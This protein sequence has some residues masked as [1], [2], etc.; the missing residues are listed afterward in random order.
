MSLIYDSFFTQKHFIVGLQY[1]TNKKTH[2]SL[3]YEKMKG[4][5]VSRS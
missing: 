5:E 2:K 3:A 4:H 1:Y